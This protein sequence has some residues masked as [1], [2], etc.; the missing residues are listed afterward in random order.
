MRLKYPNYGKALHTNFAFCPKE[1]AIPFFCNSNLRPWQDSD[2]EDAEDDDSADEETVGMD[3]DLR[4]S[5]ID[6]STACA[7]LDKFAS[8]QQLAKLLKLLQLEVDAV[9][10]LN[11]KAILNMNRWYKN[12][13]CKASL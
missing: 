13:A 12:N 11:R 6:T 8:M 4:H 7:L 1:K 9:L 2:A 3:T 5:G 10:C